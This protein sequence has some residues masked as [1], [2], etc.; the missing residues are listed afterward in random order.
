MEENIWEITADE[1]PELALKIASELD[2][3]RVICNIL[4]KRGIGS[5]EEAERFLNPKMD[6][7]C[8]PYIFDDMDRGVERI[9]EALRNREKLMIYGDYD[10]DGITATSLMFLV[11]NK[12]GADVSYFLPN[13]LG[14]GYG[15]SEDGLNEAKRRGV[16][17]IISVDCGITAIEEVK[18]ASSMGIECIITDHHEPGQE[19]PQAVAVINPKRGGED[20]IGVELSGVGLAYKFAT[21]IYKRLNQDT[22][23]LNEHLDLVALGTAADI[24]PLVNENRILTKFGIK[25]VSRTPKPGLKA[26]IF[27]SGLMG[28][29][30]STGQVV[31]ILAPRINAVGRLGDAEMAIKLLATKDEQQANKIARRLNEENKKRKQIDEKTLHEALDMIKEVVDLEKDKAIVLAG[32]KWH[33]GVIGIVASRLV[34]KFHRPT[35]MISIDGKEGKGSARSIPN[36]HLYEALRQ[37]EDTLIRFG[38]HKY[39]AGLSIADDRITEFRERFTKVANDILTEEDLHPRIYIDSEIDLESIDM[40]L[41]NVLDMFSP[42]GPQNMKPVFISRNLELH[43]NPYIVGNNHLKMKVQQGNKVVDCIGFGLGRFLNQL[44]QRPLR[45]DL[46]YV[47]E[48]NV[49]NGVEH[50][51]LRIKDLKVV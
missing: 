40:N 32:P 43:G 6:E 3:P 21:A 26:L 25:Q 23:D 20:S 30:I 35:I 46:V 15:I 39:A 28:Q 17:L 5:H 1:D 18:L 45:I 8:D 14:E 38:G 36:F 7:L 31:F 29:E 37:C 9:I 33:Q 13:R 12:L 41:I 48:L 34:E 10:V 50:I 16:T 24:V 44:L 42:F 49:W 22:A 27:V 19:I 47:V 4:V 51:Q 11:L 2:I